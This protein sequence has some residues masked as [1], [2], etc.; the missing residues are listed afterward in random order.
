[1][2]KGK[3]RK[4]GF[5]DPAP[6]PAPAPSG[7][8]TVEPAPAAPAI[9]IAPPVVPEQNRRSQRRKNLVEGTTFDPPKEKSMTLGQHLF[10]EREKKTNELSDLV[11][12]FEAFENYNKAEVIAEL[13][14]EEKAG[15]DEELFYTSDKQLAV[16]FIPLS[17][18]TPCRRTSHIC[19]SSSLQWNLESKRLST[20]THFGLPNVVLVFATGQHLKDLSPLKRAASSAQYKCLGLVGVQS[21]SSGS[22]GG[23][24]GQ[25]SEYIRATL[26]FDYLIPK[27]ELE[28]QFGDNVM[29]CKKNRYGCSL[30]E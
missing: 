8:S 12:K 29:R 16:L 9:A 19:N 2:A 22:R 6:A 3:K 26:V 25:P 21:V 17:T 1:M 27:R 13:A 15:F 4:I 5:E 24:I 20:S 23:V 11:S 10:R 30:C 7:S 18:S 14:L 28:E